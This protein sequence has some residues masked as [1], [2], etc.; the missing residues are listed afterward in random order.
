[1]EG[2]DFERAAMSREHLVA[3][4]QLCVLGGGVRIAPI[5]V[6]VQ[7]QRRSPKGFFDLDVGCIARDSQDSKR[8]V[9]RL[10]IAA[11]K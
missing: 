5:V 7:A 9:R 11:C 10:Q 4:S 6:G 2:A 1:V 8:I 3:L